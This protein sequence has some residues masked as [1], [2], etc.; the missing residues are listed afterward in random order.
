[1]TFLTPNLT[2]LHISEVWITCL[3][4]QTICCLPSAWK[5]WL[6]LVRQSWRNRQWRTNPGRINSVP[7]GV[8]CIKIGQAMS[9]KCWRVCTH[10]RTCVV[11]LFA[12]VKW[13]VVGFVLKQ[14]LANVSRA[15]LVRFL[16]GFHHPVRN[17]FGQNQ[18]A[19]LCWKILSFGRHVRFSMGG[20][21]Q[22]V[23][24]LRADH[25]HISD[26]WPLFQPIRLLHGTV[27]W[28]LFTGLGESTFKNVLNY[29]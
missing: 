12:Q 8:N 1:M 19:L 26:V 7:D 16:C 29:F 5:V 14:K 13:I 20:S 2:P 23:T 17:L 10:P 24:F 11:E 6:R 28:D 15:R 25:L 27:G 3:L 22:K 9:E 18:A 21:Y 4:F